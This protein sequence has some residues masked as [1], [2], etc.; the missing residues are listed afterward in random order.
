MDRRDS[1]RTPIARTGLSLA[2]V[3][4][5]PAAAWWRV[6]LQLSSEEA[7]LRFVVLPDRVLTLIVTRSLVRA[8]L[9]PISRIALRRKVA[10]CHRYLSDA[11][12]PDR[13][14]K[15][16]ADLSAAIQIESAVSILP[17]RG[18]PPPVSFADD[19]LL[20]IP[21]AAL[22]CGSRLPFPIA[23]LFPPALE[24]AARPTRP[25]IRLRPFVP[26]RLARWRRSITPA[27][28]RIGRSTDVR[29]LVPPPPSDAASRKSRGGARCALR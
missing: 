17:S 10:D 1:Y 22:P 14:G 11:N 8:G 24:F 4:L 29:R 3:P 21:F 25:D 2:Q 28:G 18:G 9:C 19:S 13:A 26:P 7:T 5:R 23:L 16:L 20:G 15:A 12:Q 27:S 6:A